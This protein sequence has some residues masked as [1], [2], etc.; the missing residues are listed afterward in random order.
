MQKERKSS[1]LLLFTKDKK[2]SKHTHILFL[3]HVSHNSAF[4]ILGLHS[5]KFEWCIYVIGSSSSL[6]STNVGSF[7]HYLAHR[8]STYP[9]TEI[10]G[11]QTCLEYI[12]IQ[13]MLTLN[14]YNVRFKSVKYVI[15]VSQERNRTLIWCNSFRQPF[16]I[17]TEK[18]NK[19]TNKQTNINESRS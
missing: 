18:T 8:L 10:S 15:V 13:T 19:Q 11:F 3:R 5:T 17:Y 2:A 1:I 6:I 7:G 16:T 14:I 12:R 9:R 4:L